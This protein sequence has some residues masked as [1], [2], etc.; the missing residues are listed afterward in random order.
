MYL[1][2]LVMFSYGLIQTSSTFSTLVTVHYWNN[3][4]S[5][6]CSPCLPIEF[7][8]SIL[9]YDIS[10]AFVQASM[11]FWYHNWWA[12]MCNSCEVTIIYFM[13]TRG[14]YWWFFWRVW[15]WGVEIYNCL[16]WN[17]FIGCHLLV[18][19]HCLITDSFSELN[20]W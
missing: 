8:F 13:A 19:T 20:W 2:A 3:Y 14:S 15:F 10:L 7:W 18:R 1:I 5:I 4:C 16:L 12:G 17:S 6:S 11:F 9:S